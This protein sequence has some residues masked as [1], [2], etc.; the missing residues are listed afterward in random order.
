M[1]GFK[2]RP[3]NHPKLYSG[4]VPCFL[5]VASQQIPFAFGDVVAFFPFDLRHHPNLG[6][7]LLEF[8]FGLTDIDLEK[9]PDSPTGRLR[10]SLWRA[11]G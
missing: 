1:N 5:G 9:L 2:A 10:T 3:R 8:R 6:D 7:V 11:S 4:L